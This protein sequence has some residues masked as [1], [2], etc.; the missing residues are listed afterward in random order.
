M[1]KPL[2]SENSVLEGR[3][4]RLVKYNYIMLLLLNFWKKQLLIRQGTLKLPCRNCNGEQYYRLVY[5]QQGEVESIYIDTVDG[6]SKQL[7]KAVIAPW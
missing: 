1:V 3:R 4:F 5:N 7:D 2:S 6:P